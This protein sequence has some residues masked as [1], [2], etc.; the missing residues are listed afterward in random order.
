VEDKGKETG[1]TFLNNM[2]KHISDLVINREK[3]T[4]SL[5]KIDKGTPRTK[6]NMY[7]GMP[8]AF[9]S[10]LIMH[11]NTDHVYFW[12]H[13]WDEVTEWLTRMYWRVD[14]D[15]MY[16]DDYFKTY[17]KP[18]KPMV[19]FQY[20]NKIVQLYDKN[21]GEWVKE[22]EDTEDHYFWICDCW[23]NFQ[24][25]SKR[26]SKHGYMVSSYKTDRIEKIWKDL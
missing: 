20:Q 13:D 8:E 22:V 2:Q 12:F 26:K 21:T 10:L 18:P 16:S 6:N 15:V 4:V 7:Y 9:R 5:R 1:K 23:S 17:G 11:P 3:R 14:Y 25:M 24:T 19:P